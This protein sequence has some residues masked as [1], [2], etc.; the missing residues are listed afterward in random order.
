MLEANLLHI[1]QTAA[2]VIII[3]ILRWFC[4]KL[5][6][7]FARKSEKVEHRTGLI[8]KYIEFATIFM[9]ILLLIL[10]WG[11][12]FKDLGWVLS[13]VFAVIGVG[14]FAQWSIL[15]NITSGVIM[16]FTFPYKIGD[17]ITIHDKEFDYEG[18]IEDIKAFQIILRTQKGDIIA[19]PN[20]M[21][22]QKGVS[23][24]KPEEIA[25]FLAEEELLDE[26]VKEHPID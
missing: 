11:V 4:I 15:S 1:I 24:I 8:I 22:L 19:Y 12:E 23:V 10:I 3:L 9:V 5:V 25:D 6:R 16:F 2:S 13:S 17:Y 18:I 20:S 21:L 26:N 14:F 7:R